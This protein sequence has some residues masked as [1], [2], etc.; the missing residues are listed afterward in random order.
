[1]MKREVIRILVASGIG[2]IVALV[3]AYRSDSVCWEMLLLPFYF[4]GTFYTGSVLFKLIGGVLKTYFSGQFTSLL[5]NPLWGTI[6]CL[7][8]LVLGLSAVLAFAW[9]YGIGRCI[10]SIVVAHQLDKQCG[11]TQTDLYWLE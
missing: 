4:V 5:M 7:L 3:W 10:Y 8:F 1:M 11:D 2:V 9:L 6:V